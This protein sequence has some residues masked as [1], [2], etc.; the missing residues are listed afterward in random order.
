MV[1]PTLV[2][3]IRWTSVTPESS[4]DAAVRWEFVKESSK[5]LSFGVLMMS[6]AVVVLVAGSYPVPAGRVDAVGGGAHL[7]GSGRPGFDV[8]LTLK[9]EQVGSL[10]DR[11]RS[12]PPRRR[13]CASVKRPAVCIHGD[14]GAAVARQPLV[15]PLLHGVGEGCG[16]QRVGEEIE[17]ADTE[18][19]D[20]LG[21]SARARPVECRLRFAA[22]P[23]NS[24]SRCRR[25]YRRPG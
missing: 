1:A 4:G 12:G 9:L 24:P 17:S 19:I 6:V 22:A 3:R 15:A 20:D 10:H 18:R 2:G 13:S 16:R 21:R 5:D 23:R 25:S 8:R 11:A 7:P 14:Q